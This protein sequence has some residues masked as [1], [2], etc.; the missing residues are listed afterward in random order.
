MDVVK[1]LQHDCAA[2]KTPGS[3]ALWPSRPPRPPSPLTSTPE[4]LAP[5]AHRAQEHDYHHLSGA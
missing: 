3:P 1:F 5:R 4:Q 2:S